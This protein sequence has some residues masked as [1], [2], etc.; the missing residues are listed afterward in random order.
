MRKAFLVM[1]VIL[2]LGFMG[3][4]AAAARS[5]GTFNFCV[6]YGGD[7]LTLDPH[8]G[9]RVN[10]MIV[11]LSLHRSLYGWDPENNRPKLDL[12]E[13]ADVSPDGLV[14]RIYL[15]KN[16]KFHNG[17]GM[18]ADDVIWSYERIM[19]P[20]TASLSAGFVRVIKGAKDYEDGKADKIS[21]LRKIDNFTLEITM[22]NPVDPAYTL[23]EIGTGILPREEVEKKGFDFG[24]EPVGCGPFKFVKWVKGSEIVL[25]RNPDYYEKG[26][27]YLD[28]LVYK[29]MPEGASR[30]LAFRAK[31]L[32]ATVVGSTQYPAYKADP[33]ISKN[34]VEVAE[35]FTRIIGFNPKFEPFAKKQ[36]RQ[37]INYAIDSRLIIQKLLKEKAFP[38]VSYL[39]STSPAFDPQAKGYE[40]NLPKAKALMKEAGYEKGFTFECIGMNNEAWGVVIVEAIMPFLK[41]I[42][43]TVKPQQ[44]EGAALADR[45][46]KMDYQGF[47]WSVASGAGGD[48]LQALNRWSSKNPP[49]AGNFVAYNNPEFDKLLDAASQIRDVSKR[50]DLLRKADAIFREDAPVWFFNYNKAVVAHQPWVHGIQTVAIEMMYQNMADIWVEESSP[51]AKEK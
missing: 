22:E 40:F 49:T 19:S 5:G 38:C 42:N 31:E 21:G 43:V 20:K 26:K 16:V 23:Y 28:K 2:L 25:T 50:I 17:R 32:D 35:L 1:A 29:I 24:S 8:K 39:P 37:A 9:A 44:L 3:G 7:V 12:G 13:K 11:A 18:T 41:Q 10:D 15:K 34:M 46:R 33:Q 4:E 36:V 14:Y 6:P 47:I 27:P 48:P 45:V 30:D 51:R